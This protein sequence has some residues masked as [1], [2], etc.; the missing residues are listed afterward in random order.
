MFVEA[1][2]HKKA[3][4]NFI[5]LYLAAIIVI[6]ALYGIKEFKLNDCFYKSSHNNKY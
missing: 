2:R 5:L 3:F 4:F 1:G 6:I